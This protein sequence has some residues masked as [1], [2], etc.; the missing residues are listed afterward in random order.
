MINAPRVF[1]SAN[2][3]AGRRD[4][5]SS[6]AADIEAR[7]RLAGAIPYLQSVGAAEVDVLTATARKSSPGERKCSV[8]SFQL[9]KSIVSTV[10]GIDVEHDD[11]TGR[12]ADVGGRRCNMDTWKNIHVGNDLGALFEGKLLDLDQAK[13]EIDRGKLWYDQQIKALDALRDQLERLPPEESQALRQLI[14]DDESDTAPA[15]K[16]SK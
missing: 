10:P 8:P 6:D 9:T 1:A 13:I 4:D 7:P 5:V 14:P 3:H 11:G 15:T 16:G 2:V 12:H